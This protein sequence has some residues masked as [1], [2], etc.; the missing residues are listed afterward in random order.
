[1]KF[2]K[3]NFDKNINKA[4]WVFADCRNK[5]DGSDKNIVIYGHNMKSGNMFATLKNVLQAEWQEKEENYYI[6]FITENEKAKYQ[7]FST[8]QI[9][10]EDYYNM[11]E[12][13]NNV[14]YE[15]FLDKIKSRSN[16]D[17]GVEITS[18][19]KILKCV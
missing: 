1:M 2:L 7:V 3:D 19:N 18:R 16:K 13:L 4:G 12:F 10:A 17:F 9:E 15:K 6:D 8:Y 5:F 11:T 14:S